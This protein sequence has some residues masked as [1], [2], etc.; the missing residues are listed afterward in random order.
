MD[1]Y[2]HTNLQPMDTRK[3]ICLVAHDHKKKE[4]FD[5]MEGHI[6][7]LK[8]HKLYGT[9]T[10]STMIRERFNLEIESFLSGPVGGDQQIGAAIAEGKIDILIFFW[11]PLEMQ[12]HDPDVRA[13]L[14]IA[15]LYDVITITTP[16]TAN[17]VFTS[18]FMQEKYRR[19]MIDTSYTLE[20]RVQK[21]AREIKEEER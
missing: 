9:G 3:H 12:P 8:Q 17:F 14:R 5:W 20:Q 13:L 7:L 6:P 21:L 10:T 18:P 16:S 11:D 2:D 19:E 4:L 15:V 1:L